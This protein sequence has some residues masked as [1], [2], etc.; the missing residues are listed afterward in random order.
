MTWGDPAL[1][2]DSRAVQEQL[3]DFFEPGYAIL[4]V[5][6]IL[7]DNM[8][9]YAYMCI[10]VYMHTC[11]EFFLYIYIER[12]SERERERERDGWRDG[13]IYRFM[14]LCMDG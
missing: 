4:L 1:G 10:Y 8:Y 7:H 12:E 9:A 3:K 14:D 6:A 13:V 5:I 2:G 11:V